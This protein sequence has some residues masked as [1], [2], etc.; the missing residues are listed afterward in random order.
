[1]MTTAAKGAH[2]QTNTA[3]ADCAELQEVKEPMNSIH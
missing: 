1:M 3:D 2:F